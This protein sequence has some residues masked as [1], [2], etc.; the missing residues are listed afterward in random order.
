MAN[1]NESKLAQ[2]NDQLAA[3]Q[4]RIKEEEVRA[5]EEALVTIQTKPVAVEAKYQDPKTGATWSGR[6]RQPFWIKGKKRDTF[7]IEG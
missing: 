6:G 1:Q 4:I 5:R 2:L 7:L 3:L